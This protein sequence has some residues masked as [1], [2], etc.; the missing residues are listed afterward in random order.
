MADK[1]IEDNKERKMQVLVMGLGRC[2]TTSLAA[3]LKILG[4]RPN[5]WVD[6]F[7]LDQ[8]RR[9]T[10]QLRAKYY[11]QGQKW[12]GAD[13]DKVTQG[14]DAILDRPCNLFTEELLAAYP[15]A[16][17][18]LNTRPFESWHKSMLSTVWKYQAWPTYCLLQ[19]TDPR[20]AG[21]HYTGGRLYWGLFCDNKPTDVER[22]R[23]AFEDHNAHVRAIV[24]KDRL[25]EYPLGAGWEPLCEF[26]G[27]SVPQETEFPH[28]NDRNTYLEL[29][30]KLWWY[31]LQQSCVNAIKIL[32]PLALGA[33]AVGWMYYK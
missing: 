16:R 18:I 25:L 15:S 2:G 28:I 20:Y 4:Y 22:C 31:G 17:V 26:L 24:P 7:Y 30:T 21:A 33:V 5:D 13:F 9:W 11:G 1:E 3:A 14:F 6:R 27:K 23:K 32:G 19:Y 10:D 12:E 8:D 29:V